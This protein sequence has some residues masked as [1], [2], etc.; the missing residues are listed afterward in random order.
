MNSKIK[1][2][3]LVEINEINF[4]IVKEYVERNPGR[5]QALRLILSW[6]AAITSAE[7]TYEQN[8]PWIQWVSVHT[9]L[10]FDEHKVF[11]LGDFVGNKFPQIFEI[12]EKNGYTIGCISPMNAENRLKDPAYFIPD[13]WTTTVPDKSWWSRNLSSAISQVVNDNAK[14]KITLKSAFTLGLGLLKFSRVR[15][16]RLYIKLLSGVIRR[17]WNKALLFDLFLSD[18]HINFINSRP[19]DLS[20]IFLNAGAHIQHHYLLNAQPVKEKTRIL[21]PS[22][23][24]AS[25]VDPVLDM[26]EA[27]NQILGS[28]IDL[29]GMSL[30]LATGL[31]QVP[32]DRLK[33][34]YRLSDHKRFLDLIGVR[35]K[36]VL[37]RMTRDFLV[38][39]DD[40]SQMEDA[41]KRLGNIFVVGDGLRLF[42]A[43]EERDLSAFV[44]LTY[45]NEINEFSQVLIDGKLFSILD[46]VVFVALKNG[47]HSQKGYVFHN[48]CISEKLPLDGFHVRELFNLL[49]R[50]F[51]VP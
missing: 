28:Y 1:P 46:H 20:V 26:L 48:G 3:V 23:Y 7:P 14:S 22:W 44:T 27:Y 2:L 39:F 51:K 47:M 25:D 11:R 43:I 40:K 13:P 45:Q 6:P 18:I 17:P 15:N 16:Y 19:S 4:D 37:P 12:L 21:N 32:Y 31:S 5:F 38:E 8:E 50:Y 9:G 41:V 42:G 24:V 29:G 36:A 10:K 34:Y 35:F 33:Y 49:K 30:L